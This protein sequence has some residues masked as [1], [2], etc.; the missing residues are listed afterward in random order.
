[1]SA[2]LL[3]AALLGP[4]LVA[5][6]LAA[7]KPRRAVRAVGGSL[8]VI[9]LLFL[10]WG[11][12]ESGLPA[13]GGALFLVLSW[14]AWLH[15]R[16]PGVVERTVSGRGALLA[17]AALAAAATVAVAAGEGGTPSGQ[18]PASYWPLGVSLAALALHGAPSRSRE[19]LAAGLAALPAGVLL[20]AVPLLAGQPYLIVGVPAAGLAWRARGRGMGA[21]IPALL[22]AGGVVAVARGALASPFLPPVGQALWLTLIGLLAAAAVE[23]VRLLLA[24]PAPEA[25]R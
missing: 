9:T 2:A 6:F 7:T 8:A 12:V 3:A 4:G 10:W 11:V 22:L 15:A 25:A 19:P 16:G 13:L 5:A 24:R 14:L 18:L 20:A 17:L 1:M 23:L 21:I